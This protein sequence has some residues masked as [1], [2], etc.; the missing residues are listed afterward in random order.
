MDLESVMVPWIFCLFLDVVRFSPI[1]V[2]LS[3]FQKLGD[4]YHCWSPYC[5]FLSGFSFTDTD[6]SQDCR[7]R[8]GTF[9]YFTPPLLPTH[10][11]SD[12]YL[13]LC[14]WDDYHIFLIATLVFTRL[15]LDEIYYLI[16]LPFDWLID[17]VMFICFLDDLILGFC[18]SNLTRETGGFELASITILVLQAK[19]LTKRASHSI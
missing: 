3:N 18:Y 11:H 8:E 19:R 5:F 16:E 6:D 4:W 13:Q 14:M 17:D 10:Q 15:L 9:L 7:G 1:S 2:E 12:I